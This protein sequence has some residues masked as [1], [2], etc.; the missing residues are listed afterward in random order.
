MDGLVPSLV[1]FAAYYLVERCIKFFL[2][3]SSNEFFD[4]LYQSH[5][6]PVFTGIAMGALITATI[7]PACTRSAFNTAST[8]PDTEVCLTGRG[9]LWTSELNRL[10][11]YELYVVHHLGGLLAL[12]ST[13]LLRW[14]LRPLLMIFASLVSEIPG[15]FL[16]MLAA[17][18]DYRKETG[19]AIT[20]SD[21]Y[22]SL[23]GFNL[24]QYVL[25]R[26]TAMS[27]SFYILWSGGGR[28]MSDWELRSA[29]AM[30]IAH[31]IFCSLYVA[32]QY[33]TLR[34]HLADVP[35]GK[36]LPATPLEFI[37]LHTD[38]QPYHI[39]FNWFGA[40]W[41]FT[42]YG[43]FMGLGLAALTAT[44][45]ILCPSLRAESMN[46]VVASA[47][48]GARL[49]SLIFEDGLKQL[50]YAP[51]P[52][53]FRP[54]FWLHGGIAGATFAAIYLYYVGEV[55]DLVTFGGS[56]A[57]GLPLFEFFSRIG[58]HCYGCC[59]GRPLTPE[60]LSKARRFWLVFPPVVY[61]HPSNSVL[62]RSRPS[63]VGVPLVPIQLA[64]AVTF[65]SLFAGVAVPLLIVYAV[66]VPVVGCIILIGHALIRLLTERYRSDY[67]GEGVKALGL[68]TTTGFLALTQM[69]VAASTLV[70][71]AGRGGDSSITTPSG[72]LHQLGS[73][74]LGGSLSSFGLGALVYGI[75]KGKIGYWV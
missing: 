50:L 72:S 2:R 63:W 58:C 39:Q 54:G 70:W 9:I 42:I 13:V 31:A 11:L 34:K 1:L 40:P 37:S 75:H 64:S 17:Y 41:F 49:F 26:F 33:R 43:L 69:M 68:S 73:P 66:P 56:L 12:L 25:L 18:R 4:H 59:Y 23:V 38:H 71:M 6:L 5:K 28:G 35:A 8:Y 19:S 30:M 32:R 16:W 67:R 53:I 74:S 14:P 55:T 60:E 22:T 15:D 3:R 45:S 7:T 20:G 47:V 57:I 65:F 21:V 44:V 27:Y 61:S 62:S 36:T 52:T 51:I 24:A 10:D 46:T 48:L 29:Y